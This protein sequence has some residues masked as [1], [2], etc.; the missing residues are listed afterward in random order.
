MSQPPAK[1][2][3]VLPF[4]ELYLRRLPSSRFYERSYMHRDNVS[5]VLCVGDI[6]VTASVDGYLKFW[7][8]FVPETGG[9]SSASASSVVEFLKTFR[10]HGGPITSLIASRDGR[11]A[12]T[13]VDGTVKIFDVSTVDMS[14]MRKVEFIPETSCW[15]ETLL[16]EWK[17]LV[18]DKESNRIVLIEDEKV[19]E[20]KSPTDQPTRQMIY[21]HLHNVVISIDATGFISIWNPLKPHVVPFEYLKDPSGTHLNDLTLNASTNTNTLTLSPDQQFFCIYGSDRNIRIFRMSTGKLYRKYDESLQFYQ[22][23][24]EKDRLPDKIDK[25]QFEKR[26]IQE[27][28]LERTPYNGLV[29]C[30]YDES[31]NFIL[32]STPVGIKVLNLI[33]NK[34]ARIIGGGDNIRFLNLA[35]CTAT[36]RGMTLQMAASDNPA[37]TKEKASN[38]VVLIATAFRKNR[39]YLFTLEDV[40]SP[41]DTR[42]IIN[43]KI[44]QDEVTGKASKSRLL[45]SGT[46]IRTTLG[47][48]HI[49]LYPEQAPL[50]VENFAV[51]SKNGYYCNVLFHRIIKGFMI[52]TGDPLGDGTGGTSIWNRDFSDEFHPSLRHDHPGTVSMANAGRNTNGSQFFIT[53]VKCPWL[54]DKHTIFGRVTKGMDVIAKIEGVDVD[55]LDRPLKDV[56]IVQIDLIKQ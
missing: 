13:S 26:I 44:I 8:R 55:K 54:D 38:E 1:K 42:D 21:S 20:I 35:L 51:H 27:N 16:G 47:D 5:H 10:A 3:K 34:L 30:L 29:N 9:S 17:L 53:T 18:A 25:V 12:S 41:S 46:I 23:L 40:T 32:F 28:E 7:R 14:L 22:Q 11:I 6:I 15:Y 2:A 31:G 4:E 52:Q 56:K 48:I 45:P 36:S 49:T 33:T 50:A 39:F 37:L 24:C 43:E 19:Q